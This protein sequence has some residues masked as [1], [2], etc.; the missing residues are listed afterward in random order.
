MTHLSTLALAA[1]LLAPLA[2]ADLDERQKALIRPFEETGRD[3]AVFRTM[4]HHPRAMEAFLGWGQYVLSPDNSLDPRER[5]LVILRVGAR[6][7][8]EYEFLRHALI[9]RKLGY[10]DAQLRRIADG[11][12]SGWDGDEGLLPQAVDHL[13]MY[14]KAEPE[15][16]ATLMEKM[17]K[18]KAIDVIWTTGQYSQVCMFLLTLGVQPDPD[19]ANDPLRDLFA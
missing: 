12:A 4:L 10:S 1:A 19:I 15:L 13:V 18:Q 16:F 14:G 7:R 2:D 3:Y 6:C 5:E 17:G 11:P 9:A 8:C